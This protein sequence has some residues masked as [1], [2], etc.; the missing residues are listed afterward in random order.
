MNQ[1]QQNTVFQQWLAAYEFRLKQISTTHPGS[2]QPLEEKKG[3]A[4]RGETTPE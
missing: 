4:S 3:E 2:R 1:E